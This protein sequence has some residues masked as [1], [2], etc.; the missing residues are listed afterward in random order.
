MNEERTVTITIDSNLEDVAV[1]GAATKMLCAILEF[2]D[3][4]C[5]DIELSVSEAVTNAVLHAYGNERGHRVEVTFTVTRD[6]LT[7]DVYDEGNKMLDNMMPESRSHG[8]GRVNLPESG[9]GLL[10]IK[11]VM[12]EVVYSTRN[13]RNVLRMTRRIVPT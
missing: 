1:V 7:I 2:S 3:F 9:M 10:I 8:S 4:V 13:N 11:N 12:D 6:K 5:R